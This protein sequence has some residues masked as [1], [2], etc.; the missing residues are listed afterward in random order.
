MWHVGTQSQIKYRYDVACR[1]TFTN[2][3]NVMMG[4]VGAQSL[5][6]RTL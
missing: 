4:H 1:Y 5:I 3:M 2:K 6:V